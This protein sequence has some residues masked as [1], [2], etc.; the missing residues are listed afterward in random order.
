M[1]GPTLLL[2]TLLAS[3]PAE[4]AEFRIVY[5]HHGISSGAG[6]EGEFGVDQGLREARLQGKF[7]GID[8][9]LVRRESIDEADAVVVGGWLAA[10]AMGQEG[11]LLRLAAATATRNIPVFNAAYSKDD[12]RTDCRPNLF[13]VLPSDKMLADAVAQ[14]KQD[15]D[16]AGVQARAWHH[17]FVKFAARDLNNR[18]RKTSAAD[19]DDGAWAGW[20]AV[21]IFADA[22]ANNP[23]ATPA[24]RLRYLRE[25][26]EFDGQ[27]GAYMTFRSTGQLRQPLLLVDQDGKLLG[28]APVRG[29]ADYDDLDS[30]GLQE[31]AP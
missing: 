1:R 4:T 26:M 14:W 19:M 24:E 7:L 29:V 16:D 2:L 17:D 8:Y 9:K 18:F 20:A 23:D 15:H 11:E 10:P 21:K 28:E 31:C 25:E 12:L 27:K 13:H 5:I 6:S 3:A 22:V 30:L